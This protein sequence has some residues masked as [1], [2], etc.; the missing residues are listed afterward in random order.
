METEEAWSSD[1]RK[2]TIRTSS[3]LFQQQAGRTE[4]P[5]IEEVEEATSSDERKQQTTIPAT[6]TSRER[7]APR[8]KIRDA[9]HE[10]RRRRVAIQVA[11]DVDVRKPRAGDETAT[12]R[13]AKGHDETATDCPR[14][15]T[16]DERAQRRAARRREDPKEKNGSWVRLI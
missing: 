7:R 13:R 4:K 9:T 5:E 6:E 14:G 3:A 10:P 11:S 2:M 12:G 15:K 16:A 8:R 1:E